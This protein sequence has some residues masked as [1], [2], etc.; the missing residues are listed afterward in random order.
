MAD[1]AHHDLPAGFFLSEEEEAALAAAETAADAARVRDVGHI[2]VSGR[3][4]GY[5]GRS[6]GRRHDTGG[7]SGVRFRVIHGVGPP[8]GPNSGS[9]NQWS[10]YASSSPAVPMPSV[11]V[12]P[13]ASDGQLLDGL[14]LLAPDIRQRLLTILHAMEHRQVGQARVVLASPPGPPPDAPP[15]SRP[16]RNPPLDPAPKRRAFP[17]AQ[18]FCTIA[19]RVPGCDR[20]CGR[21]LTPRGHRNHVCRRCHRRR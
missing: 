3:R 17:E 1:Q 15:Q 18:D 7:W 9:G 4:L 5:V 14:S 19:C 20:L 2:T 6:A 8:Q 21:P 10:G 13:G 11:L 16:G 12:R